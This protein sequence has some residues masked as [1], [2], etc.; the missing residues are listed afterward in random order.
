VKTIEQKKLHELARNIK[1]VRK[2]TQELVTEAIREAIIK[3]YF[4]EGEPID[5]ASLANTFGVSRMPIRIAL[6]ELELEGLILLPPHKKPIPVALSPFE[7]RNICVIRC[8]MEALAI[9]LAIP[10]IKEEDIVE[11]EECWERM[12]RCDA[13][14]FLVLN[15]E[16]HDRIYQHSKNSTLCNIINQLRNNVERYIR[17]YVGDIGHFQTANKEHLEILTAIKSKNLEMCDQTIR[18][19]L[20]SVCETVACLLEAKQ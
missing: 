2:T 20:T 18:R 6:K 10:N 17:I 1:G 16:F 5:T 19:H 13:N 3:G 8:E 7:V 11:L 12:N 4:K 9:R 14:E 15:M